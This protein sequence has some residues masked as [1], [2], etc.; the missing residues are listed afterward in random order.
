VK[1]HG[2]VFTSRQVVHQ[3]LDLVRPELETGPGYD[4]KTFFEAPAGGWE[5]PSGDPAA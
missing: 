5:P 2:E 1:A 4:D 3:I